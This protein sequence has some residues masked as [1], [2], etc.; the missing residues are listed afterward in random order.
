MLLQKPDAHP[1]PLP[2]LKRTGIH[3]ALQRQIHDLIPDTL[4]LLQLVVALNVRQHNTDSLP[5]NKIRHIDIH[6]F[7]PLTEW[8]LQQDRATVSN[9]QLRKHIRVTNIPK[10]IHFRPKMIRQQLHT[11]LLRRSLQPS[12][13]LFSFLKKMRHRILLRIEMRRKDHFRHSLLPLHLKHRKRHLRILTAIIHLR[14]NVTVKI[15]VTPKKLS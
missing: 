13:T 4:V 5:A 1:P 2:I 14:K 12:H 15:N 9:A 8:H 11:C 6:V 10:I 3:L 7:L